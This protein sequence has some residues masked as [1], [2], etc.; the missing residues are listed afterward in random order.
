MM[1]SRIPI[2]LAIAAFPMMAMGAK[3]KSAF[4]VVPVADVWSR[5]LAASE[6]PSDDLRET[7]ILQG[8]KV[9]IHE[10]SG[11][12][13]HIEAVEQPEFTH[14][15]KW[16]GYPGWVTSSALKTSKS[17]RPPLHSYQNILTFAE[18]MIGTPYLWGGLNPNKDL[19]CSG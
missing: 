14:H 11:P 2:M 3:P 6:K 19:D 5:P 18:K 9:L 8:E 13:V 7:Q 16:E 12:W 10:S 4:V 15:N 17:S 1:R